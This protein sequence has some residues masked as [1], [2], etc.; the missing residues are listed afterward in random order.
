MH[1]GKQLSQLHRVWGMASVEYKRWITST[2]ML[3]LFLM[4]VYMKQQLIEPLLELTEKTDGNLQLLE[5]SIAFM[6]SSNMMFFL[7]L[8]YLLVMGDFPRQDSSLCFVMPRVG[9]KGWFIG[10]ILYSV[11][12][13]LTVFVGMLFFTTLWCVDRIYWNDGKWSDAVTKYYQEVDNNFKFNLITGRIYN[14]MDPTTAFVHSFCLVLGMLVMISATLLLFSVLG[15][16]T[17]GFGICGLYAVIGNSLAIIESKPFM[18]FFPIAHTQ[19]R[20]RHELLF[21]GESMPLY[22]SYLYFMV[23]TFV[24]LIGAWIVLKKSK[25]I[26]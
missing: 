25:K 17:A 14:Q 12:A 16:K 7:P 23:A 5:P 18:W 11:G 22:G 15:K 21:D 13:A 8:I 1:K 4:I 24:L 26:V 6:G 19:L 20:L 10:Q 2:K 9:K 3:L